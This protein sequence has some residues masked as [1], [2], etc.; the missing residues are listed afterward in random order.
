[1]ISTGSAFDARSDPAIQAAHYRLDTDPMGYWEGTAL[2]ARIARRYALSHGVDVQPNQVILTCG[3]SPALVNTAVDGAHVDNPAQMNYRLHDRFYSV[4]GNELLV[5]QIQEL[6]ERG[7]PGPGWLADCGWHQSEQQRPSGNA[8][9]AQAARRG[10]VG[11]G[12]LQAPQPLARVLYRVLR[13]TAAL[14]RW[15]KPR[16]TA[17]G[18]LFPR[19]PSEV[20]LR[21]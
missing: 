11:A 6:R 8:R 3:A 2:T 9:D 10:R 5:R 1:M 17:R 16:L 18:P 21:V 7:V 19:T 4:T 14:G 13:V 15:M 12:R 20:V